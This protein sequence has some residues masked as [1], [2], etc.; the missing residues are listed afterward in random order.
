M[1]NANK[2]RAEGIIL[3]QWLFQNVGGSEKIIQ[4][5]NRIIK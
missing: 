4:Y 1:R 3:K 5:G 2:W